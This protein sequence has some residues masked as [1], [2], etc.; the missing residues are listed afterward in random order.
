MNRNPAMILPL[1]LNRSEAIVGNFSLLAV[2]RLKP[3]GEPA[4]ACAQALIG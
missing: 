1:Q 4:C 2:A 3:G